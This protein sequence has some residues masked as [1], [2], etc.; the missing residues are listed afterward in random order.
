MLLKFIFLFQISDSPGRISELENRIRDL[1][2]EAEDM[3]ELLTLKVRFNA[4]V[5]KHELL[6][7]NME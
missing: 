7:V 5:R 2:R 1:E 6:I 3:D 4:L